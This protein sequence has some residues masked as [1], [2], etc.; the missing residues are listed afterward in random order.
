MEVFSTDKRWPSCEMCPTCWA[1]GLCS[2]EAVPEARSPPGGE[3][4]GDELDGERFRFL[5]NRNDLLDFL[6]RTYSLTL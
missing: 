5:F 1:D 3:V 4:Q 2:G 6:A